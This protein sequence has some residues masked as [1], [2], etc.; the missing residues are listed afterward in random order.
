[1]KTRGAKSQR[2][3]E[4]ADRYFEMKRA[5]DRAEEER[6]GGGGGNGGGGVGGGMRRRA[7]CKFW[8]EG[9]CRQ[10]DNCQYSHEQPMRMKRK[11]ELCKYFLNSICT[12][13]SDCIYMHD[14][15][16]FVFLSFDVVGCAEN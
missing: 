6:G 13:G 11:L 10:G 15:L 9:G 14:I 7:T 5:R 12:K 1:M 4:K 8:L 16:A 2:K 3:R